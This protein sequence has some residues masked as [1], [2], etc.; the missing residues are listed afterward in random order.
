MGDEKKKNPHQSNVTATVFAQCKHSECTVPK[1]CS[2][3]W[4]FL[5]VREMVYLLG[6]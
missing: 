1:Y 6:Q 2:G 5:Y 3:Y 4:L